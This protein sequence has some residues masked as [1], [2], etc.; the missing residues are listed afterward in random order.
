MQL[1]LLEKNYSE[2]KVP[3]KVLLHKSGVTAAV[4]KQLLKKGLIEIL[5]ERAT[6]T[7]SFFNKDFFELSVEQSTA[8]KEINNS[9][10]EKPVTLLHGVTSSG[11]TELYIR[12]IDDCLKKEGRHYT[13]FPKLH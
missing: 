7:K 2:G 4:L 10:T 13:F 8:L 9:F 12:L 3:Q 5:T 6:G 1:L 11:K